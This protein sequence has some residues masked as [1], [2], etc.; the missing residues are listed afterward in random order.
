MARR[1]ASGFAR[2]LPVLLVGGAAVV[3][4]GAVLLAACG[5]GETSSP[6]PTATVTV[7]KTATASP[8]SASPSSASPSP[9]APAAGTTLSLYFLR[10]EKLGVAARQVPATVAVATAA[11]RALCAGPSRADRAAGLATAIPAG[12]RVLSV[13]ISDG[14]ATIDLSRQFTGGGG[15]L[16]MR[17]RVAQLVYTLTRYP[18]IRAVSFSVEG[19]PL[20]SLGGE[21]LV[22]DTPQR[23]SAWHDFEPAIFVESPGAGARLSSPF[24]VSGS[25]GVFEGSFTVQLVDDSGRR[26][27]RAQVQATKGAP[28]RGRF[29]KTIPFTTSARRGWLVAYETSMEDGS[30]LNV[31][32]IPVTFVAAP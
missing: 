3:L 22:L 16:S 15:S 10:D 29:R 6:Q 18:T 32:R 17:A 12:T 4:L 1:V 21:G 30:R 28:A 5:R 23:R 25:A 24:V 11:A 19:T 9:S 14:V 20:T 26:I 2:T 31:V 8:S 7:T 27:V 13:D